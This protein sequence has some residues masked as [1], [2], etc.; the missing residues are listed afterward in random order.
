MKR[1]ILT[2]L[3]LGLSI[4]CLGSAFIG[5]YAN[6]F[7][8]NKEAPMEE[9]QTPDTGE[10]TDDGWTVLPDTAHKWYKTYN[11]KIKITS[12]RDDTFFIVYTEGN[13]MGTAAW[14][15]VTAGGYLEKTVDVV[16]GVEFQSLSSD[17]RVYVNGSLYLGDKGSRIAITEDS[18]IELI[19]L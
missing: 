7:L 2:V 18:V 3:I 8:L 5:V 10:Q 16:D 13:G 19:L 12:A 14:T 11:V 1:G 6:V 9:L 17:Y 4:L 15:D